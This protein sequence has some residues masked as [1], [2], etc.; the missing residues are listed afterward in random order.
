MSSLDFVA[1][2]SKWVAGYLQ[3]A[4]PSSPFG[5]DLMDQ[6]MKM[7]HWTGSGWIVSSDVGEGEVDVLSLSQRIYCEMGRIGQFHS[8]NFLDR[9]FNDSQNFDY[10]GSGSY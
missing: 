4:E 2:S 7:R 3:M 5:D 8:V 10:F 1:M 6:L 9:R